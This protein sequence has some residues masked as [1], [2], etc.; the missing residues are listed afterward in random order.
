MDLGLFHVRQKPCQNRPEDRVVGHED[1]CAPNSLTD[2]RSALPRHGSEPL[3]RAL[4]PAQSRVSRI[5]SP[6]FVG[7]TRSTVRSPGRSAVHRSRG[8]PRLGTRSVGR[9]ALL[10]G[11]GSRPPRREV[12]RRAP[13]RASRLAARPLRRERD[14]SGLAAAQP[15]SAASAR[16]WPDRR[17]SLTQC[18]AHPPSFR[19]WCQS[20]VQR[21]SGRGAAPSQV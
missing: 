15:H 9:S 12:V 2:N 3:L 14:P 5:P 13:H 19:G 11:V 20:T 7:W 6:R 16:V 4:R 1:S 21:A 17:G 18:Q 10:F 8:R